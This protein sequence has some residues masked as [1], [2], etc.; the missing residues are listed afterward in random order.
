MGNKDLPVATQRSDDWD[1][2]TVPLGVLEEEIVDTLTRPQRNRVLQAL[3]KEDE[4][5][6]IAEARA[7]L[8]ASRGSQQGGQDK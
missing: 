2:G 7:V 8:E 1:M 6:R 3:R 4:R 5:R